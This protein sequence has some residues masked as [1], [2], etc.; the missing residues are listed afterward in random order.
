MSR[1]PPGP[2]HT[3]LYHDHGTSVLLSTTI[4]H[5]LADLTGLDATDAEEL[6]YESVDIESL[7]TVFMQREDGGVRES[8]ELTFHVDAY[9]IRVHATGRIEIVWSAR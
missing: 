3:V 6:L 4:T 2:T 7:N 1:S 9:D 8:G 5:A